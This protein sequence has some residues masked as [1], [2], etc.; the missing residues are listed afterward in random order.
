VAEINAVWALDFMRD[1][2]YGGRVFRTLNVI[3]EANRGALG[4]DIA[5]SIPALRVMAFVERL[6]ELYGRPG[7]IRCDNGRELTSEAFG[8]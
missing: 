5:V 1:T 8:A 2:L 6:I 7:A 4:I 3:D